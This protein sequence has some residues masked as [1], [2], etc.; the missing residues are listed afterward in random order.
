M[1]ETN[2]SFTATKCWYPN[3]GTT[4]AFSGTLGLATFKNTYKTPATA[5]S[6]GS[7]PAALQKR[8]FVIGVQ[9]PSTATNSVQGKV[10]AFDLTWHLTS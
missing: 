1:Q 9:V 5:L 4:C 7:G 3:T 10:A 8:Y 6:L 2:A